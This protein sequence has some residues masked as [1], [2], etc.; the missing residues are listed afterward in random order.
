MQLSSFIAFCIASGTA[1]SAQMNGYGYYPL[2]S[3]TTTSTATMTMTSGTSAP[4]CPPGST[5][6]RDTFPCDGQCRNLREDPM[7]CGRCGNACEEGAQCM[8]GVCTAPSCSS[9]ACPNPFCE[10]D[11]CAVDFEF[12]GND[13][14]R[15]CVFDAAGFGFFHE[16]TA[17]EEL[18]TCDAEAADCR[19]GEICA[20]NTCCD[21]PVCVRSAE[22]NVG[23]PV[24]GENTTEPE[25]ARPR[26]F[27]RSANMAR[28][29]LSGRMVS[30]TGGI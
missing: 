11:E 28:K 4:S 25:M 23:S 22:C 27:K 10:G 20:I 5:T 1:V 3:T 7:H 18:R 30:T 2:N 9:G 24:G 14:T 29:L 21:R 12:C 19:L 8:N 13:V 26:M 15:I 6:E 17:C 16:S